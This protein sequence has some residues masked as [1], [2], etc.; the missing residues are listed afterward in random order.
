MAYHL[1]YESYGYPAA[2]AVSHCGLSLIWKI[3]MLC[4]FTIP[5]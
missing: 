4:F 2:D 1:G 3:G 5:F